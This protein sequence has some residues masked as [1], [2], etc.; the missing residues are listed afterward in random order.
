MVKNS[1][2]L[3]A[4]GDAA[5]TELYRE[6]NQTRMPSFGALPDSSIQLIIKYIDLES[7]QRIAVPATALS[8]AAL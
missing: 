1:A 8:S 5:A 3:I 2:K 4:S 7:E 6:Y